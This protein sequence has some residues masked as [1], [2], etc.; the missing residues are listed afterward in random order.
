MAKSAGAEAFR[1][2]LDVF[3]EGQWQADMASLEAAMATTR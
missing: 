3:G 2:V 1:A